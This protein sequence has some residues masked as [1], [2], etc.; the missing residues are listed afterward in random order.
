VSETTHRW[1]C[2]NSSL[3]VHAFVGTEERYAICGCRRRWSWGWTLADEDARKCDDC[4]GA[5]ASRGIAD[6]ET[7]RGAEE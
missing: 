5:L 2:I 7:P 3:L 6:E 4:L 1:R